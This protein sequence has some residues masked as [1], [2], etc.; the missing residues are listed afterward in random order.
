MRVAVHKNLHTKKW[1]V[2]EV[3]V[4]RNG[5]RKGKKLF[6][7]DALTLENVSFVI[8]SEKTHARV[9]RNIND[10]S[11]SAGREVIAYA[12]GDLA[13]KDADPVTVTDTV[14]YHITES[15]HFVNED[16]DVLSDREFFR[17]Y[18]LDGRD[19]DGNEVY[20]LNVASGVMA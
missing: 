20:G 16:G 3:K 6:D 1:A 18:F 7:L 9:V 5:E 14:E 4:T 17:V 13:F 15:R 11:V 12:V 19:L 2:S 10:P 8:P